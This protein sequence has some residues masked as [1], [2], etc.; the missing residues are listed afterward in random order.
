MLTLLDKKRRLLI[1]S[2]MGGFM[3]LV[4][5]LLFGLFMLIVFGYLEP[6][7]LIEQKQLI[8]FASIMLVIGIFD[9]VVG[10]IISQW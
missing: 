3:I 1:L 4:G 6:G 7:V 2:L 9:F 8:V 5:I 10:V